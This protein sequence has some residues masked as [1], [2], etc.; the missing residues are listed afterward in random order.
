MD[1]RQLGWT[2]AFHQDFALFEAEGLTPARVAREDKQSYVV[3]VECG[4][5]RA[6]VSGR[7]RNNAAGP[8]DFPA[9][10]DW[11]AIQARPAEQQ[12]TIHAV[13]PRRSMFSRHAAGEAARQQVL[14]TNVDCVFLVSGLD[15]D[16][17]PRRIERYLTLAW[18]SGAAPVIVLNKADVCAELDARIREVE[19][20]ALGV[21]VLVVS[22]CDGRGLA[23]LR[24][25]VGPG[26]TAALLGSSGVGKSS[27]INS[28]LGEEQ[29]RIG[30]VREDDSR[31]RHTT[32]HRE[33]LLLP[34]GGI[35]IDTPGMRELQLWARDEAVEGAFGDIEQLARACRFRDCA[36][37]SEPGCAVRIAV[38][39]G[40]LAR[41]RFESYLKLKRELR[42]AARRE[43]VGL[44]RAERERWKP[45]AAWAKKRAKR[46]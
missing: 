19:A 36:H 2:A 45:I 23:E 8:A 5:L 3:Y 43:D 7:L 35:V 37:A 46:R 33:L 41:D 11:V 22:A 34:G 14:A 4:P 18:E 40:V 38:A 13:L 39:R 15:G 6:S 10:G 31:G 25:H 32:T 16:F 21:P 26:I 42:F 17:N 20:I 30:A 9:V 12:A 28:L 24:S 44:I 1:L 29:L 27:L